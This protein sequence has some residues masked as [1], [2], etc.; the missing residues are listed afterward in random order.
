MFHSCIIKRAGTCI[1]YWDS[2]VKVLNVH[3]PVYL[4]PLGLDMVQAAVL[5]FFYFTFLNTTT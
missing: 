2:A 4:D 3:V 5:E 1:A